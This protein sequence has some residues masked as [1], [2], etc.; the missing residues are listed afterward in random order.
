MSWVLFFDGE[1][2]LCCNSI[3][4][5]AKWDRDGLI[6][7]APLQGNLA[8]EHDLQ[9]HLDGD[10]PSMVLRNMDGGQVFTQSDCVLQILRLLGGLWR[11]LLV[12]EVLPRAISNRIYQ[13]IAGNRRRWFGNTGSACELPD[14][15]LGSR[16]LDLILL[17]LV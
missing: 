4:R 3:R 10:H 9:Q 11:M 1:C 16:L 13:L 5:L 12:V 15:H 14:E 7:Y 2:A 6:R 8:A 17:K